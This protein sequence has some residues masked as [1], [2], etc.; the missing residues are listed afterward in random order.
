MTTFDSNAALLDPDTIDSISLAAVQAAEEEERLQRKRG[1][2]E[3]G[4]GKRLRRLP[5]L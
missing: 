2:R 4:N 5:K 3:G 1:E